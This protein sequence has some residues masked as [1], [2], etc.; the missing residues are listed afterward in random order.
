MSYDSHDFE[1]LHPAFPLIADVAPLTEEQS[2]HQQPDSALHNMTSSASRLHAGLPLAF[3]L[4]Q[5]GCTPISTRK[6][7]CLPLLTAEGCKGCL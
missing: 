1:G 5:G 4:P 2:H 6:I 7:A 3:S